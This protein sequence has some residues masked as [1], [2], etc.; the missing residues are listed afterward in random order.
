MKVF[1][2]IE[3]DFPIYSIDNYRYNRISEDAKRHEVH[4]EKIK[5]LSPT[6]HIKITKRTSIRRVNG[7]KESTHFAFTRENAI[8]PCKNKLWYLL[9]K[10]D[11]FSLG[12]QEQWDEL[13]AEFKENL[14]ADF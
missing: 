14:L 1:E 13:Y 11:Y 9:E 2:E 3:V 4:F 5:I 8:E 6:D 10:S 12:T 7:A